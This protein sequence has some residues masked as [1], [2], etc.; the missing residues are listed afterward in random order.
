MW[1]SPF[2]SDHYNT[3]E[4]GALLVVLGIAVAGL[5]YALMLVRQVKAADQGTPRMQEIAAAVREGPTRTWALS[6]ARSAR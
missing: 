2:K 6:S 5:L 4:Q 1:F 3:I